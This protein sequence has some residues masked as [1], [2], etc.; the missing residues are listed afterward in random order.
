MD[1]RNNA[2]LRTIEAAAFAGTFSNVTYLDLYNNSLETLPRDLL[3]WSLVDTWNLAGNNWVCECHLVWV[4]LTGEV[5][6]SVRK[7]MK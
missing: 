6:L 1:I 2:H 5:P 4:Q 3:N 7:T